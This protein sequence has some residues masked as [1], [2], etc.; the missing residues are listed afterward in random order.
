MKK[1]FRKK[2]K[3]KSL[4]NNRGFTLLFAVLVSTLVLSV[5]ASIIS[6]ALKQIILSGS[7]R[8]SQFAFYASNTGVECGLYWDLVG[9]DVSIDGDTTKVP[10]FAASAG[11]AV[12]SLAVTEGA[13]IK[14]GDTS[15]ILIDGNSIPDSTDTDGDFVLNDNWNF[16]G[17]DNSATT[18]FRATFGTNVPYCVDV[19]VIKYLDN[20]NKTRTTINSRGYNTC[21]DNSKRRI[22]RGLRITY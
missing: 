21:D 4:M 10:V 11:G 14:C 9:V 7:A 12:S 22:E 18:T 8:D 20:D 3:K 1:N 6:I 5:G 17:D 19:S 15:E 16:V 2:N 13:K